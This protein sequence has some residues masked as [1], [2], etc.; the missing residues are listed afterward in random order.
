MRTIRTLQT[1]EKRPEIR[2][3]TELLLYLEQTDL[4]GMHTALTP[5]AFACPSARVITHPETFL[6]ALWLPYRRDTGYIRQ[7]MEHMLADDSRTQGSGGEVDVTDSRVRAIFCHADVI[8]AQIGW[9]A[10]AERGISPGDFPAHLPVYSGHY[11]RP[12]VVDPGGAEGAARREPIR[13][14]GSP[15]QTGMGEAGE[16][17]ALLVLDASDWRVAATVPLSAESV[18]GRR[19]FRASSLEDL[20][21]RLPEWDPRPGDRVQVPQIAA[22]RQ[23][24]AS[25]STSSVASLGVLLHTCANLDCLKTLQTHLVV[26]CGLVQVRVEDAKAA[27]AELRALERPGIRLE[28]REVPVPAAPGTPAPEARI[29]QADRLAPRALLARFLLAEADRAAAGGGSAPVQ[30]DPEALRA[31]EGVLDEAAAECGKSAGGGGPREV[32]LSSVELRG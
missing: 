2:L 32:V 11:H 30:L 25:T 3:T 22:L 7:A 13:Y 10:K 17:K 21:R 1:L 28:V 16:E 27:R 31:A 6:G 4:A 23:Y 12:Q 20:R 8:G 5:L 19:H 24:K 9:G 14:V 18:G 29:P 26:I 15:Y